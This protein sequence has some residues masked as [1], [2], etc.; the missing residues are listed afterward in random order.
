MLSA[1][2]RGETFL[3]RRIIPAEF[4]WRD[5]D[6]TDERHKVKPASDYLGEV[7]RAFEGAD[8]AIGAFWPWDKMNDR[9]M[10]FRPAEVTI[11]AGINGNRKSMM[12]TQ[13][14]LQLMRQQQPVLIASFEMAPR[15]T[16]KRMANQAAGARLPSV[17]Y[18]ERLHAWTDGRL[19]LY[20]HLG[21]CAPRQV[22]AVMRYAASEL[23]VKHFFIDSLMKVV[24]GTDDYSGQKEFIGSLCAFSLAHEAHVHLVAHARKGKDISGGIDKWDIK[25]ASEITDQVD[26]VCLVSKVED[27][28][29][30]E[31]NQWLEVA[32]QRN[33]EFEGRVGLY[34]DSASLSFA[35]QPGKRWPGIPQP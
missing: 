6:T 3:D 14:A 26:N 25:G 15:M 28:K 9:G 5:Y 12:T 23:G 24:K 18:L 27:E 31:P 19:W 11:Y 20:D 1:V 32:K 29:E 2:E 30:G 16:L 17:E 22:L 7:L 34:F 35:E 8:E 21:A 4:D 10:R 13:I 33:G